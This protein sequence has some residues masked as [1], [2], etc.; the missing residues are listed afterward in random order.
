MQWLIWLV[1]LL[2][3][4][5]GGELFHIC[6]QRRELDRLSKSVEHFL[7]YPE[8]DIEETLNEGAVANLQNA[9]SELT[10]QFSLMRSTLR[11]SARGLSSSQHSFIASERSIFSGTIVI[12]PD[13]SWLD[14]NTP[15]PPQK[16]ATESACQ[17]Q[18]ILSERT[19]AASES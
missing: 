1:V 3:A 14:F 2:A 4:A 5:L 9:F 10:A 15:E 17:W 18:M 13:A 11:A 7:L 12:L 6:R 19:T 16:Q 8:D